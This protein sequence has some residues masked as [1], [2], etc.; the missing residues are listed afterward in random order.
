MEPP[1]IDRP[2]PRALEGGS[3]N[4]GGDKAEHSRRDTLALVNLAVRLLRGSPRE[5]TDCE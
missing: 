2:M 1:L 4:R 5:K 3:S